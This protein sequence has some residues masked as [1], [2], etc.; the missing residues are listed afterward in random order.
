MK[1]SS[2]KIEKFSDSEHREIKHFVYFF[3]SY[4]KQ[5]TCTYIYSAHSYLR[6]AFYVNKM[7]GYYCFRFH[8]FLFL[9]LTHDSCIPSSVLCHCVLCDL[10]GVCRLDTIKISKYPVKPKKNKIVPMF[11]GGYKETKESK[12]HGYGY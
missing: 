8:F 3:I 2:S 1:Y 10:N 7:T 6:L 4:S 11:F 9:C 5:S 12:Q